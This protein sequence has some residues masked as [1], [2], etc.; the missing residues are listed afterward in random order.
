MQKHT[1]FDKFSSKKNFNKSN[2]LNCNSDHDVNR[3]N[4]NCI[5]TNKK[6]SNFEKSQLY[7]L[8]QK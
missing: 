5:E 2:N 7:F 4:Y 1:D 3:K 8:F 6:R